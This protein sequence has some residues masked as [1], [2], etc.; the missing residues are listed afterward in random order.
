MSLPEVEDFESNSDSD[1]SVLESESYQKQKKEAIL[2]DSVQK[3]FNRLIKSHTENIEEK[4]KKRKKDE[5]K[6]VVKKIKK[7]INVRICYNFN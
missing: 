6:S 1:D 3:S 2:F 7:T 4:L 5:L